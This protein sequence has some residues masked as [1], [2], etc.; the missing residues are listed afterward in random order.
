ME[1]DTLII[2]GGIAGL[3]LAEQLASAA[4]RS[5]SSSTLLLEKNNYLGGRVYTFRDKTKGLQYEA[6]AGRIHRGHKQVASL[7]SRFGLK[8]YSFSGES[9]YAPVFGALHDILTRLP[10]STLRRR[11]IA[12]LLP[13]QHHDILSLFPYWAETHLTRADNALG[14][15]Q[16]GGVMVDTAPDAFYGIVGGI[17]TLTSHLAD[18]ARTAGAELRTG[19]EVLDVI[20]LPSG[21]FE[22]I[23]KTNTG[24]RS[25]VHAERVVFATCRCTLG[26]FRILRDES[27]IR[28]LATSP[29]LR[30][31]ATYPPSATTGRTWFAGDS[32]TVVA[33]PLRFI[34]PINAAKGLIMI[35]YTDGA[36][37]EHWRDLDGAALQR[38]IQRHVRAQWPDRDIPEPTYLRKHYWAGGCTYWLPG[39]Y[40]VIA[41]AAHALNPQPG[42]YVC[43]ESISAHQQAWI[44]GALET[45]ALLA[46]RLG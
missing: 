1:C 33:G 28:H 31:Y 45:A 20:R 14:V 8:T 27:F 32:N 2:G 25:I 4:K 22:A 12:E 18:A 9:E 7:V 16:P 36:D 3:F 11:T 41:E 35:S 5:S 10:P 13:R 19:H 38:E 24:R 37:T 6:G 39:D 30:I 26:T 15:F 29:L 17:D 43:G 42:V 34:I 46:T 23:V 40:D 44:E 21:H